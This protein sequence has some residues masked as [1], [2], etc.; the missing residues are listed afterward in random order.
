MWPAL[1]ALLGAGGAAA[2]GAAA[3]GAAAGAGAAGAGGLTTGGLVG[4]G[5]MGGFGEAISQGI[6][7]ITDGLN[8][9]MPS[10]PVAGGPF[11]EGVGKGLEGFNL[12][13]GGGGPMDS[14]TSVKDD[15]MGFFKSLMSGGGG[16]MEMGG[17]G[18][19][20]KDMSDYNGIPTLLSIMNATKPEGRKRERSLSAPQVNAYLNSLMG[21]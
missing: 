12:G 7:A 4:L 19:T 3:G 20:A 2:G 5:N 9:G 17:G 21:G 16:G 10:S 8:T 13:M 1:L 18:R 6:P 14:K 11:S 15:P